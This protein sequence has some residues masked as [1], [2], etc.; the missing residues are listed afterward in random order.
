[1]EDA[2]ISFK[3]KYIIYIE[4][5]IWYTRDTRIS[6]IYY[7]RFISIFLALDIWHTWHLFVTF[8]NRSLW[9]G[10]GSFI[11]LSSWSSILFSWY[12]FFLET[13]L[14]AFLFKI[15]VLLIVYFISLL[16]YLFYKGWFFVLMLIEHISMT[17]SFFF[18]VWNLLI[19]LI[20]FVSKY[21][22]DAFVIIKFVLLLI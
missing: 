4:I 19:Q 9:V 10:S 18:E 2:D 17:F 21:K 7:I 8:R 16:L 13:F 1:M 12:A 22:K 3:I 6:K 14:F 11:I 15:H 5:R 20:N